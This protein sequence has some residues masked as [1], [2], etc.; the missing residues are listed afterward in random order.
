MDQH[1]LH[2]QAGLSVPFSDPQPNPAQ[3]TDPNP[4]T[5]SG[6]RRLRGA[7]WPALSRISVGLGHFDKFRRHSS[8]MSNAQDLLSIL[9]GAGANRPSRAAGANGGATTN[10]S[11]ET[12]ILQFK[13]GKMNTRLKPNG[14]Y[15]VEPDARRGEM[16][17]VWTTTPAAAGQATTAGGHLKIEWKDRRTKTTVN[18]I[19]IFPEDDATFERVETGREGDR[20]YLLQCGTNNADSRHF[21]W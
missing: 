10:G 7:L 15:L 5:A 8:I 9:G 16:H 12:S 6:L 18:T 19:P 4:K 13:A 3:K 20:V 11:T 1:L 17:V 14:K 2:L 21:F